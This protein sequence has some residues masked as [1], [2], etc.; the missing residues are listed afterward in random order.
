MTMIAAFLMPLV[1]L[2]LVFCLARIEERHLTAYPRVAEPA[3]ADQ[4]GAAL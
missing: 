2:A 4:D 1:M 3:P